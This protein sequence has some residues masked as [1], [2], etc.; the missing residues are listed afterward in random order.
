[1]NNL[2]LKIAHV[3]TF[4]PNGSGLYEASRNMMK[5]DF[6]NGHEVF[7]ID[8]GINA[9]LTKQ[10]PRVGHVDDRGNYKIV[11]EH[12]D[13]LNDADII[14]MHTYCPEVWYAKNQI[15][16]IWICHGRPAAAFRQD[17]AH[18]ETLA[19]QA[20][21]NI[22]YWPR[23]KKCVHFWPEYKPY[24]DIIMQEGKQEILDYPAIDEKRF[25]I[26]GD[27]W[28]IK[29]EYIGEINGLICDP[30]R[31]DIDRFDLFV[32]A[33]HAAKSIKG[34]KWHFFGLDTPFN[35]AEERMLWH[36]ERIG[37]LGTRI[38]RVSDMERVYRAFDFL[39]TPHRIITQIV[40]EAVACGLPV[41]ASTGNKVAAITIDVNNPNNLINAIKNIRDCPSLFNNKS[42]PK[43]KNFGEKM[44]KIYMDVIRH[45]I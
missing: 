39:Y 15:P 10:A 18:P 12:Q 5:A 21:G 45:G 3:T 4:S 24:W 16:F 44:N 25:S 36:I 11:V 1:M 19:Y 6:L 43:L 22:S 42:I 37:A 14:V 41:I 8:T 20:Y 26:V 31:D 17:V 28:T 7:C 29:H 13:K 9:D 23:V 34:L 35:S 2:G 38:G 33:Y 27:K 30:R 40:G 32:G